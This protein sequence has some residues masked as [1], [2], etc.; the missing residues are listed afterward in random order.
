VSTSIFFNG[1]VISIPGSYS[2]VDASGLES[3]GLGANGIVA[4]LGT[5]EGGVPVAAITETKDIIR[6]NKPEKV[7]KA[8]RSGQLREVGDML[9]GPAKDSSIQGGAVEVVMMK[10]NPA[11]QSTGTLLKS[12]V[13]QI[14]LTSRDY[15]A[16]TEQVNVELQTGTT[17]GKKLTIRFEDVIETVDD[18]G[19]DSLATLQYSGGATGYN[20]STMSV[21]A[22]GDITVTATRAGTGQ[23][24]FIDAAHT[25]GPAEVLSAS[26]GD[27]GQLVTVF[28]LVGGVATKTTV[29]LNGTTPV[30]L[31]S[32]DASKLLGVHITGATTAGVVTV[33]T[34]SGP[35]VVFTV[36]A[37]NTTEGVIVCD[38][39]YVNKAGVSLAL[40]AA[41]VVDVLLFGRNVASGALAEVVATAG[42]S[43]VPSVA[44]S[45]YFLDFIV[46][47]EVPAARTLTVTAEAAKSLASVQ[48]TLLKARDY[49]NAKSVVVSGPFT[50]GFIFTLLT[51]STS[52]SPALLD[53]VSA[54][55]I[56]DPAAGSFTADLNAIVAWIN[57]NSVIISAAENA[58]ATGVPDNTASPLFLSGGSEGVATFSDYQNALNL[59]KR[60]RVNSV[61][62]LSGDPAVAAALDAH[63]A[64]MGGIGRSERDGFVG[65]LNAAMDDVPSKT[66]VKAQIVD[67]NSRHVRVTAQAIE[68]FNSDGEKAEFL[69][70]FFAAVLAGA[71]AGSPVGTSL[72]FKS[73]NVLSL[74]QH[75]SW[76]PTDD[77]E[78][79]ITAG[80][81]F[82]EEIEGVGRRVVR[83]VTTH[84][85]SNN[86]AFTE[87]SVNEAVNYAVYNFR[88]RLEYAVGRR[89][90]AGTVNATR[91]IAI[92]ALGLLVDSLVITGYRSLD[93]ELLVD[94][95]DVSVELAPV[96]PINFVRT[97]VH[98][99]TLA[100]LA[101]ATA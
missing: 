34:V 25:G 26:A 52:L 18:L 11:L 62:D 84:L 101:A 40:D 53:Q 86:I 100:Q 38:H 28:G 12:G 32:F 47:G 17:K 83:N 44:T 81:C 89:G 96:I 67:I 33:R 56:K 63:C 61:V 3:V 9:F 68:R 7:R 85:S 37:G 57:Q 94:V 36:P 5:A 93:L 4:V 58:L 23:D 46:V 69:P 13:A 55:N 49:F 98:L 60:I 51:G 79:M 72:T 82:A 54:V 77:A 70:P 16:F 59:L 1:R 15:G 21:N 71:Q 39:C 31:G 64:Y 22:A 90:F 74:R 45:Y 50:R 73:M 48:K 41:G 29:A 80:L 35:T 20:T 78:E 10:T 2:E 30:A 19:G 88:T 8:F 66:E 65:L 24:T 97:N 75:S 87:G 42:A 27:V 6:L 14:D 76:N 92:G 95:L 91:G 99:V 43:P